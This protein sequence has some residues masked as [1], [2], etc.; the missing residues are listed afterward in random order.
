MRIHNALFIMAM[1]KGLY[2]TY[3]I[4][5]TSDEAGSIVVG[6]MMSHIQKPTGVIPYV[7]SQTPLPLFVLTNDPP[8]S[9]VGTK[10]VKQRARMHLPLL[11]TVILHLLQHT[12]LT[13]LLLGNT[14]RAAGG[15]YH[16]EN[17]SSVLSTGDSLFSS[18]NDK[19]LRMTKFPGFIYQRRSI[20]LGPGNFGL[21]EHR[22]ILLNIM[23]STQRCHLSEII[24]RIE[25]CVM[26]VCEKI[27][28]QEMEETEHI[29]T[30]K[31]GNQANEVRKTSNK[32]NRDERSK[33][34]GRRKEQ[35][36]E[37]RACVD[38]TA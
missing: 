32:G 3:D 17:K 7:L 2:L 37:L 15:F 14:H 6:L 33:W 21:L 22:S 34:G 26:D 25:S 5:I 23:I 27:K 35:K 29:L 10:S 38:H 24:H 31:N 11:K 8:V 9:G 1:Y 12:L 16:H 28:I 36:T 20:R 13:S 19:Y 18:L 30:S 4:I